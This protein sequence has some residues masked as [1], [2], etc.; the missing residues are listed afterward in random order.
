MG[1]GQHKTGLSL[2]DI[3]KLTEGAQ[4]VWQFLWKTAPNAGRGRPKKEPGGNNSAAR[5]IIPRGGSGHK[6]EVLL[7]RLAQEHP[8]HFAALERGEYKSVRAAAEAAG[9]VKPS[10]QPLAR[11][12]SYW[13]KATAQ[14]RKEFLKWVR[15]DE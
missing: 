8:E 4:D 7:A 12:K 5:Q 10:H 14:E 2:E 9:L 3:R 6:K 13:A 11:L 15:K 1:A